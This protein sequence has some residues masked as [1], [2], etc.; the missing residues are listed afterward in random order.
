MAGT[1]DLIRDWAT[2]LEYW[3]QAALQRVASGVALTE[4][5]YRQLLDLF[6]EDAGLVPNSKNARPVLTFPTKLAASAADEPYTIDRLFNLQN[7]NALPAAQ[8]LIFGPQLTAIYGPNGSGK[9]SYSRPLGCA[10]FARGER[11]VLTDARKPDGKEIP[12]ADIEITRAGKKE[13]VSW[14]HGARCAHLSGVYVFDG[15]SVTAHLTK[16]NAL[17]FSPAGLSLL[18]GLADVT[19]AVR[20]R[21]RKIIEG[22]SLAHNFSPYFVGDSPVSLHLSSS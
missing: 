3:E 22:K 19:D 8:D 4:T 7:V 17:S 20:E 18:T 13:T 11:E 14:T 16:P 15:T 9:T 10:G 12:K 1:V 5:D 2:Q 21:L 6:M